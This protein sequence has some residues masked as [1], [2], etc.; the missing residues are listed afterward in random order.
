MV[1]AKKIMESIRQTTEEQTKSVP[2]DEEVL[3][4][5]VSVTTANSPAEDE[6]VSVTDASAVAKSAA[7]SSSPEAMA[8][9][10]SPDKQTGVTIV[11]R[12]GDKSTPVFIS[13]Q[14]AYTERVLKIKRA[15]EARG[16]PCWMATENMVGNVQDAIGEALMVAPAI[17]ICFSH[18]Y[19][20]SVYVYFT[21]KFI[22]LLCKNLFPFNLS[23][24]F[25]FN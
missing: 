17:V 13:Y 11:P 16:I 6:K 19:R 15:L 7:T 5:E 21:T 12:V 8:W 1:P 14:S 25:G 22:T 4:K 18:S 23:K 2:N 10:E 9:N 3:I 24:S 20:E